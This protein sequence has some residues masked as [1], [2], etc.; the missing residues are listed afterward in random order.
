MKTTMTMFAALLLTLTFA[1][2]ASAH[3]GTCGVGDEAAPD[4]EEGKDCAE[5][6]EHPEGA[7]E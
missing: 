4:C 3:C 1:G 2:T 5:H 7:A 6:P